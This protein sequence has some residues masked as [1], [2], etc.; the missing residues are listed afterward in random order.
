MRVYN[1]LVIYLALAFTLINLVL[2]FTGQDDLQLYF[3]LDIIAYLVI[4]LL[5]VYLNPRARGALT[6]IA[7]VLF[8]SFMVILVVNVLGILRAAAS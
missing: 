4:S 1:R 3:I 2:A 8:A 7:A 6:A 5:Y